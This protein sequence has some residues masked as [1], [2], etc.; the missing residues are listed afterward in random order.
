[1]ALKKGDWVKDEPVLVRV[2]SSCMTG[3]ILGS[4]G[5][6]AETSFMQQ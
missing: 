5:V 6:I 3:D 1:M 2:H 4:L